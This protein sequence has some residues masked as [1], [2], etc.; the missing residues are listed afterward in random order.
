MMQVDKEKRQLVTPINIAENS[1]GRFGEDL[2]TTS[3]RG[4]SSVEKETLL[5][6]QLDNLV[7]LV[8]CLRM[9]N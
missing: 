8:Q 5:W 3:G 7:T 2:P 6:D 9:V 4:L 1:E